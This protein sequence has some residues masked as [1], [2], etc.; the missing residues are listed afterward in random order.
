MKLKLSLSFILLP[1]ALVACGDSGDDGTGGSGA[2]VTTG[3]SGGGTGGTTS[4]STGMMNSSSTGMMTTTSGTGGGGPLT[5]GVEYTNLNPGQDQ[6]DILQQ[7]CPMPD[8]QTCVAF[9]GGTLGCLAQAGLKDKGAE[10]A[11][12]PECQAGLFCVSGRCTPACCEEND[13]PC[14]GGNCNIRVT[15]D[16]DGT[17]YFFYA[18]S[19]AVQCTL[20]AQNACAGALDCH[21]ETANLATCI[22]RTNPEVAEGGVCMFENQ[23]DTM[24][25]CVTEQGDPSG[26]C[27]YLCDVTKLAMPIEQGG[28]P[29]GQTCKQAG[30]FGFPNVGFCEP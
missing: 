18:C 6:C 17:E 26:I 10:C 24:Q 8:M 15:I 3:G 25:S 22:P 23:C 13:Q 29:G 16:D 14:D 28:C 1:F 21:I 7:N 11:D 4:T 19:Y 2:S 9:Q 5:C 12:D 20:F 27:R 30:A